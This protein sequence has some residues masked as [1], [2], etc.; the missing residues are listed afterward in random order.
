MTFLKSSVRRSAVVLASVLVGIGGAAAFAAPASA[1]DATVVGTS[2]CNADT[3][4]HDITWKLINDF[5]TDATVQN[6]VLVPGDAPLDAAG[7]PLQ[8]GVVIPMKSHNIDGVAT[9]FQ[10]LPGDAKSASVKFDAEWS[11]YTDRDN[12]ATVNLGEPC[13]PPVEKCVTPDNAK[14][15]HDFAVENGGSTA[16]VTLNEGIKLCKGEPVTLVSYFAPRP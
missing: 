7:Q 12:S 4:K 6:L 8:T 3:G 1:H 10:S 9:Y 16:K 11:D 15:H 5:G 13:A 2:A 14:F